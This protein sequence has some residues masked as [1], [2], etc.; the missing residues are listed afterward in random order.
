MAGPY[1]THFKLRNSDGDRDSAE[2]ASL[3]WSFT[4]HDQLSED[5]EQLGTRES[6]LLLGAPV[7]TVL[8]QTFSKQRRKIIEKYHSRP[9][10][11]AVKWAYSPA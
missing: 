9:I 5:G 11:L 4:M 7:E 1:I 8:F 2:H 3:E 6:D 10:R